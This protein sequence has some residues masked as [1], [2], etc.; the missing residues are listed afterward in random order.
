MLLFD[1]LYK[2]KKLFLFFVRPTLAGVLLGVVAEPASASEDIEFNSDVLDVNDR[3]HVNLEQFS[4]PGYIM[5]GE[6]RMAVRVNDKELSEQ[7]VRFIVPDGAPDKSLPCLSR[8]TVKQFGLK[9]NALGRL[10]W[11]KDRKCLD[12]QSLPGTAVRGDLGKGVLHVN[13]PHRYLE[14]TSEYWDPPSRWEEGLAG[15]LLDYNLNAQS[16]RTSGGQSAQSWSGNGTA[17][18]NLGAWR[19]RADWQAQYN[20]SPLYSSGNENH[21]NWS[22]YYMYRALGHL[23]ARLTLGEDYLGSGL[24]D[25]FRFTGA[26]LI[27]DDNML[28]PDLRA[29]APEVSGVAKT[30]ARVTVS[31]Q[32]RVIYETTVASGPFR[33]Q[34]LNSAF[35]GKLDVKVTEQDGSVQ[36]FQVETFSSPYLTRPGLLRYKLYSGKVMNLIRSEGGPAFMSGEF[37]KGINNNWSL[38]GGSILAGNYNAGAV[39]I[40]RNLY[41]FGALSFDVTHSQARLPDKENRNGSSYRLGYSRRFQELHSQLTFTGYRFSER[42]FMNMSQYLNAR[43]GDD[44][45]GSSKG[46]YAVTFNKFFPSLGVS[47]YVNCSYQTYWNQADSNSLTLSLAR[48]FNLWRLRNVNLNLSAY[49]THYARGSDDGLS[50]S[51]SVPV[52][53][54]DRMH[55][56]NQSLRGRVTHTAGYSGQFDDLSFSLKSGFRSDGN[57]LGSTYLSYSGNVADMT[58]NASAES[59]EY[60]AVGLSLRGGATLTPQG[61]ALHRVNIN[62]GSRMLVDA[63]G[64]SNIPVKGNGGLTYTNRFGNAVISDINSYYRSTVEVDINKLPDNVETTRSVVQGTFTEGAIGYREFSVVSGYKA[65]TTITMAEGDTP[66]FGAIVM[67]ENKMQSGI[68]SDSGSAWLTGISPGSELSVQWGG[69]TQCIIKLPASFPDDLINHRLSLICHKSVKNVR[70]GGANA[71]PV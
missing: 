48:T 2:R 43:Y 7:T 17:G 62:G 30:N 22:R 42:E 58:L 66:P 15:G 11:W 67:N 45:P 9:K 25:S 18:T 16:V 47:S 61:A 23:R 70:A 37:S 26:S 20:I 49:R 13:L 60:Q 65:M 28:P 4:R 34:E 63:D 46:L 51:I 29:Y 27:T 54:N 55:Y 59:N 44:H 10:R 33:I 69:K 50:L 36:S 8:E 14:Y 41:D 31:Q 56:E 21:W 35:N 24:F 64:V 12:V 6:Y 19:F 53:H 3:A 5:P 32:G 38:F 57:A 39:G 52:N 68:I 71:S 1:F 40:G